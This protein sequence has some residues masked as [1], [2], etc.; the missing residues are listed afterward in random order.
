MSFASYSHILLTMDGKHCQTTLNQLGMR[1]DKRVSA[2]TNT[3]SPRQQLETDT[4]IETEYIAN[5]QN[6]T[7]LQ[8]VLDFFLHNIGTSLDCAMHTHI[9]RNSIC[10]YIA[11][12][13]RLDMVRWIFVRRDRT[14]GHRAKHYSADK[15]L[16][17]D[18]QHLQLT[19]TFD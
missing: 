13:E 4:S 5:V 1:Y 2:E 10:Y 12:L 18:E 6:Y 16:W 19:L 14:T 17:R 8:K 3:P 11:M 15:S 9:L 7:D